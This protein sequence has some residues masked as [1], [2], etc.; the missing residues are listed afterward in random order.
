[1][2]ELLY[3]KDSYLKECTA[4]VVK[5][6]GNR[7][8]LDRTVFY[9]QSG[10]QPGDEGTIE[11]R[12][13]K[14]AVKLVKKENGEVIHEIDGENSLA[15]GDEVHC[16]ID[17]DRRYK[18]MRMHTAMHVIGSVFDARRWLFSGNQIGT[19]ESRVDF[20]MESFDRGVFEELVA[21]SNELLSLNADVRVG[22]MA[23]EQALSTPGMVKLANALP[24]DIPVLRTVEIVGIDFQADG[25]THVANTRECGKIVVVKLDNKGAKNKRIYF[26][27]G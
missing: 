15:P 11:T 1:M 2:A 26:K 12:G 19:D 9:A 16:A 3:L 18:L 27:L 24:P 14:F 13:Q 22:E 6:E 17:W 23:R 21:K 20:T 8:I 5:V 25:G 7:V 10:G 4:K